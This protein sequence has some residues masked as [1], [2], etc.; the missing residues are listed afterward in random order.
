MYDRHC[1]TLVCVVLS[2]VVNE[3]AGSLEAYVVSVE[4]R[5]SDL[6]ELLRKK[7]NIALI[8]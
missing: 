6:R 3:I 7:E 8:R 2:H 5:C 4:G 1:Q